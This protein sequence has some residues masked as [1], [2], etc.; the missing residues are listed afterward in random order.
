MKIPKKILL[1]GKIFKIKLDPHS[2]GGWFRCDPPTI[3]VG[4][5]FTERISEIFLHEIIET[6]FALRDMRFYIKSGCENG[7]LLFNFSHKEFEAAI[8]D[9]SCA[10]GNVKFGE[11]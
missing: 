6:I 8:L 9:I 10:L 5:K 4:T 2:G 1:C 11:R 7:D 3:S